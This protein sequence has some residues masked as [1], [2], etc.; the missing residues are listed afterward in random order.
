M[1]RRRLLLLVGGL[2]AVLLAF[3]AYRGWEARQFRAELRLAQRE[4]S[5]RR[6]DSAA[7]R[8]AR[9]AY[10]WPGDAEVEYLFGACEMMNGHAEAAMAA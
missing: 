4:M 9:L 8:L 1:T 3:L 5:A 7:V 10:R 6:F 2:G